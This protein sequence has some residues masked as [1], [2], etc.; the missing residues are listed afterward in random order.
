MAGLK[1]GDPVLIS[2]V[3]VG[4][5][6]KVSLERVGR[7]VVTLELSGDELAAVDATLAGL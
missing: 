6:A 1:E 7:V 5:V 3:K 4:R 2:G